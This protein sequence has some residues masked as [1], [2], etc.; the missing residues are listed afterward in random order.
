MIP[1]MRSSKT[2][3][4][5]QNDRYNRAVVNETGDEKIDLKRAQGDFL[6]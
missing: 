2:D 4:L 1:V 5:T 6:G 3:K